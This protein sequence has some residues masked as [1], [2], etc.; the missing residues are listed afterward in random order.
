MAKPARS[1]ENGRQAEA[2]ASAGGGAITRMAFQ[3]ASTPGVSMA[4]WPPTMATSIQP[5]RMARIASP[6]ATAEEAQAQAYAMAAP[7]APKCSASSATAAL[8]ITVS[9]VVGRTRRCS[10]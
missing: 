5:P 1:P 3:L 6:M 4:S 9:T 8:G 2:G 10:P 7:R